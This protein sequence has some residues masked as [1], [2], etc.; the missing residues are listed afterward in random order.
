MIRFQHTVIRMLGICL[1]IT[2]C[3]KDFLTL[4]PRDTLT[5]DNFFITENDAQAALI[6]VYNIL[7]R[8]TGFSNVRDAADIEWSISGD[9]EEEDGSANRVELQTL[10]FPAS[11]TILRD[12][13]EAAYL[14]IGRANIVIGR[15]AKMDLPDNVKNGIVAQALFLRGLFYYRLANYWGGVPLVLE[16]LDA[17]SDLAIPRSSAEEVWAQVEKDL[18]EAS[19]GLPLEWDAKN[20]GRVTRAAAWG[21]L[22]K[23]ALWRSQWDKAIGYSD[24]IIKMPQH[25][26]LPVFRDVFREKNENNAEVIFST[27]FRPDRSSQGNSLVKR[28]APRGAPSQYVGDGSWSNFVPQQHW[29]NAYEKDAA[30]KI[31]DRRYWQTI[32]GPGE[33]HQDNGFVMPVPVPAGYS[34][35]GFIMTKYWEFPP[36]DNLPNA[37]INPPGLRFAEVLLNYAEALN[38]SARTPEALQQVNKIRERAG[39]DELPLT[40]NRTAALDAIFYERR[41][42]FIWEPAGAFSDLNRRGRFIDFIKKNR[43]DIATLELEKKPW[44]FT[45]PVLL[46]IPR[47]AWERN[48]K[49][50]QNP[51]YTF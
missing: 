46:P 51:H 44:L 1:L 40:L 9:M 27:Q 29:V 10:N 17:S 42:E 25:Y 15:V 4:Q 18:L 6:G 38:E 41:M 48:K 30:G 22:V 16:E 36:K 13:Y 45:N 3:T 50:T 28:T 31:K 20:K 32:I 33:Q 43:K 39:L 19:A 14:G 49:L 11:N 7:E 35:T 21:F 24:S 2:G 5:S 8:E 12:V 26:L 47:A 23:A 37:G 34:S